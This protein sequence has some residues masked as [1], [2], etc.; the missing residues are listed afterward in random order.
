MYL[1]L[2]ASTPLAVSKVTLDISPTYQVL[3]DENVT[4]ELV[5]ASKYGR[6]LSP[7]PV[8]VP[9]NALI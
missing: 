5:L 9:V 4:A 2:V 6:L 3:A 1:S 7:A 8:T